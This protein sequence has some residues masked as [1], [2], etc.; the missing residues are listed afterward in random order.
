MNKASK[1]KNSNRT[2]KSSRN[3]ALKDSIVV[4]SRTPQSNPKKL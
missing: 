3:L 1:H 2:I 4:T